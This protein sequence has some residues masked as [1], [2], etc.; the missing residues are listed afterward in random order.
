MRQLLAAS[1]VTVS[2]TPLCHAMDLAEAYRQALKNDP[3]WSANTNSYLAEKE[4]AGQSSGALLTTVALSGS[5]Y[6][7]HFS[8]E[9]GAS[10]SYNATQYGAQ[11]RQPLFRADLWRDYQRSKTL[12]DVN[13]ANYR[14][15]EQ[16]QVLRVSQAYVDVLRAQETLSTAQ[17]EEAAL[18]RQLEQAQKRFEVGL[19]AKT[20]VLEAQAQLDGAVANRIS[21]EAAL[22]GSCEVLAT[23][24]G[25]D[26]G[27]LAALR[28]DFTVTPP[29]PASAEEWAK[30]ANDKN[31]QLSAARL[32]Y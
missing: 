4:K 26:P 31:P 15:K 6:K 22:A 24:V 13:E 9:T 19:I 14:Q 17:A 5:L 1:L 21:A 30:L 16:D 29:S 18:K 10:L 11:I 25:G 20:D 28:D 23:I 7:N 32:N 27:K 2:L 8:P 3:Q 12:T